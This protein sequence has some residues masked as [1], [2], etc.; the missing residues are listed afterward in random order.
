MTTYLDAMQRDP[1]LEAATTALPRVLGLRDVAL[2][3]TIAIVSPQW[4]STAAQIGPS[5]LILW[6]LA[7]A[8]FF[9]PSG[10]AVM[11]LASRYDGEGGLYVWTKQA[12]GDV[13]AF[14]AGW[15]YVVSNLVFLSTVLL[16]MSGAASYVAAQAWPG[17]KDSY[18]FNAIVTLTALWLVVGVNILGLERAKWLA[19]AG[20]VVMGIVLFILVAAALLCA[21]R[22]GSATAFGDG[23]LSDAFDPVAAKPFAT[24]MLALVGL[25]LAPL[26]GSE[27]REP[28][29]AIPQAI[30]AAGA[31]I[32]AFYLLGTA[33]L[34][35]AL[36]RERIEAITGI[37]EGFAVIAERIGFPAL[38]PS[39]AVLMTIATAGVLA[40]WITGGVRLP[41]VVGIDRHLPTI[42]A[43]L[44]PRWHSPYVALIVMGAITTLL[45][46]AALAGPTIGDAYQVLV[47]MTV[48][49][50]F[51]PIAYMFTAVPVLRAKGIGD[52]PALLRIPGG[53][54][55]VALVTLLGVSSTLLSIGFALIPPADGPMPAFYTKVLGGCA[56]FLGTGLA[57]YFV[58]R[59]S[60]A[61][62]QAASFCIPGGQRP[63]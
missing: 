20:A 59:Q 58:G 48:V 30:V 46:L 51:I 12:F 26:M 37:P 55:G 1:R 43:R 11:E 14:V 50:T 39:A 29:R 10:L 13:H 40:A 41:Y 2:L 4:L 16:F 56:L 22:H 18:A 25:E 27:I 5:S 32:A 49:M 38:G 63:N 44:H 19:N 17:L 35:V 36:P 8:V 23:L 62:R 42:L 31:L 54:T 3:Y 47:D 53:R 45:V 6:L 61:A 15:S 57:V 7:L 60:P 24:M 52:R 33:A 9:V 34:L 28:R 21:S